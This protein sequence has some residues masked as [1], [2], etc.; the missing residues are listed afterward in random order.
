MLIIGVRL[1]PV[2]STCWQSSLPHAGARVQTSRHAWLSIYSGYP[3]VRSMLTITHP[4]RL[5]LP[6]ELPRH[7]ALDNQ[8]LLF[9]SAT[10]AGKGPESQEDQTRDIHPNR[11]RLHARRLDLRQLGLSPYHVSTASHDS[12]LR[13]QWAIAHDYA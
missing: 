4:S 6:K 12:G 10:H 11:R 9:G 7:A 13:V 2:R 3:K 1:L 8:H 5:G